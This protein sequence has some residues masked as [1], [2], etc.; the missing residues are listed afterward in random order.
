MQPKEIERGYK[1]MNEAIEGVVAKEWNK[2]A[3]TPFD[4]GLRKMVGMKGDEG[5]VW[6]GIGA[7]TREGFEKLGLGEHEALKGFKN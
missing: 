5:L 2:T 1:D 4:R 3:G 7:L 6:G